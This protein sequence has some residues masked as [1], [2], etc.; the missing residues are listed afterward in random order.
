MYQTC[1]K[2]VT[3]GRV[4][5]FRF[6]V[7]NQ[8]ENYKFE[9]S[10]CVLSVWE[11]WVCTIE[12]TFDLLFEQCTGQGLWAFLTSIPGAE[13]V[14]TSFELENGKPPQTLKFKC[15]SNI[16]LGHLRTNSPFVFQTLFAERRVR[17]R[18]ERARM[19]LD[20]FH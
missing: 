6:W 3:A 17:L 1:R 19:V 13:V 8:E 9:K 14:P 12:A 18:C 16:C 5:G 20:L 4:V 15:L 7:P 2:R 11:I 10:D